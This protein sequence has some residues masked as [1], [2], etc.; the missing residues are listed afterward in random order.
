MDSMFNH[1]T[2]TKCF[3]I[4]IVYIR[5]TMFFNNWNN[6]RTFEKTHKWHQP[7][8]LKKKQKEKKKNV[9]FKVINLQTNSGEH[10]RISKLLPLLYH[11]N[12]IKRTY[13]ATGKDVWNSLLISSTVKSV[14][15]VQSSSSWCTFS[16]ARHTD[17][18]TTQSQ[19]LTSSYLKFTW[20]FLIENTQ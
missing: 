19:K 20:I 16:S 1:M 10:V 11:K 6:W 4:F 15:L 9:F 14:S 2:S 13:L 3:R 18:L 5:P 8:N 7:P 12:K 17:K